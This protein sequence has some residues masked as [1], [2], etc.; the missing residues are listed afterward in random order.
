MMAEQEQELCDL[1]DAAGP[2]GSVDL[3][4]FQTLVG[5]AEDSSSAHRAVA[6]RHQELPAPK[7]GHARRLE[8][9]RQ[10]MSQ[11]IARGATAPRLR[12]ELSIA[13]GRSTDTTV[14]RSAFTQILDH[15]CDPSA[16]LEPARLDAIADMFLARVG[17][18]VD[19]EAFLT[20]LASATAMDGAQS[21]LFGQAEVLCSRDR[22]ADLTTLVRTALSK[23]QA[24]VLTVDELT[25]ALSRMQIALSPAEVSLLL[26]EYDPSGSARALD[27]R[28]LDAAFSE[29]RSKE[30][31]AKMNEQRNKSYRDF[32]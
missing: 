28:E 21:Y 5:I 32:E 3:A 31:K 24:S 16:R 18:R 25:T 13:A 15:E 8:S 26:I 4:Y 14:P 22:A 2:R 1:L 19:Y 27:L 10:L 12:L 9:K 20:A 30:H 29:W 7:E 23:P 17:D 6:Q 11:L